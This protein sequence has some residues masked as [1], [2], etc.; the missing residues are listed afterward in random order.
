MKDL[1]LLPYRLVNQGITGKGFENTQSLFRRIGCI[2]AQ[3]Y[4]MA[5]WAVGCRIRNITDESVEK[6]FNEGRILRTHLLRPTWHFVLPEDIRWILKLTAPGIKAQSAPYHKKLGID[7]AVLSQSKQIIEKH[8]SKHGPITRKQ[9]ISLFEKEGIRTDENRTSFLIMDA[10]LDALICSAGKTENQF[11]YGLL[12]EPVH[13]ASPKNREEALAELAKRYFYTRGPATVQ[14]FAWWSGLSVTDAGK[15]LNLIRQQ[16]RSEKTEQK[17][18]YY[19]ADQLPPDKDPLN[20]YLLPAYDEYTVAYKDRQQIL[21]LSDKPVTGSGLRPVIIYHGKI[22]G[23]WRWSGP[24]NRVTIE[25]KLLQSGIPLP[26]TPDSF[27]KS[28]SDFTGKKIVVR[29]IAV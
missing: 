28:Y 24:K 21:N 12:Q 15:G 14:D 7:R 19:P 9:I 18:L 1:I 8:L 20:I 26:P 2:Q 3:E 16:L 25:L 11:A 23:V 17:I 22:A 10:E 4:P 29:F 27:I 5:K 13:S 6:D